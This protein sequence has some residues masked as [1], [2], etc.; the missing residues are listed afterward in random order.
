MLATPADLHEDDPA[1]G[2]A[3]IGRT[4]SAMM[5]DILT[6]VADAEALFEAELSAAAPI[7]RIE[8]RNRTELLEVWRPY[9]AADLGRRIR[10][11]W[12]GSE[13][14]GRGRETIWKGSVGIAGNRFG[15]TRAINRWNLDK[16]FR[17]DTGGVSFEAVTTGGFGG[18]ETILEDAKAGALTIATNLVEATIPV[19]QIGLEDKVFEAGGLGRRLR[20]FRL[21]DVNPHRRVRLSRRMALRGGEDNALYLRATLED[22]A[23]VWSSP[24]YLIREGGR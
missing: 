18:F 6:G 15:A 2:G 1:L 10:V 17:S 3:P 16:P 4:A 9:A 19:A 13:Y 22:G 24:V 12:E 21:P 5:G 11:V 7:E 14:R 23:V 8:L 20:V